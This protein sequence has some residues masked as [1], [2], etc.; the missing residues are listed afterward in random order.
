MFSLFLTDLSEFNWETMNYYKKAGWSYRSFSGIF[1]ETQIHVKLMPVSIHSKH[2]QLQAGCPG[3]TPRHNDCLLQ[4]RIYCRSDLHNAISQGPG[5]N[6]FTWQGENVLYDV[7][8]ALGLPLLGVF[9]TLMPSLSWKWW[10][11]WEVHAN[12]IRITCSSPF[13][14]T[15]AL[16]FGLS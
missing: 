6:T 15:L 2:T 3:T 14:Y 1:I 12:S 13:S 11:S 16:I 9:C 7:S 5:W 10:F 4:E 8:L